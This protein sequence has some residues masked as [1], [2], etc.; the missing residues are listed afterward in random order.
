MKRALATDEAL[1]PDYEE[2]VERV[3]YNF[4]LKRRA[5]VQILGAGL[6]IA[7]SAPALAQRRGGRGGG[8]RNIA[9]RIHLGKDGT[10]TVMVGKVEAGQGAR[11]ELSQAAAEELRVPLSRIQLVMADTSLVPDDGITAGSGST[12]RTVPAVRQGAA[13]ARDLLLDFACKRWNVDRNAVQLND[14]KVTDT[15]GQ[16]TLAYADLAASDDAAKV[17]QQPVPSDVTL[18]PVKEWKVLGNPARRPNGRDI[19]TGAHKYPSDI[20]RPGM[21]YGKVLRAPS[22]GAKLTSVDLGPAKAMK[23]VV[24]VQDGQFVGVAAPTAFLAEQARAAIASTAKWESSPHPASKDLFEY[25]KQ[26]A[27]GSAPANPFAD[28]LAKAK[29]VLR[30]SYHVAYVQHAPLEPRAAVAEWTD[31]KLTVWAGTQNPFGYRSDL[32]RA[33]HLADDRVRVVVPDL[34]GGF[35]GKHTGEAAEEAA[36]LAQAAA[37]P[38]SL[39]WT[40]EEEFTWAYFRPAALIEAEA[41]LDAKGALTSWHF[42][43]INSGGSAVDTPYRSGKTR[44]QFLRSDA[45]LRQGSYRVLAATANNFARE[46]F[47]DELA[48]AAGADPLDFRLA[49]LENARLRA[50]L[51]TAAARFNWKQRAGT[52]TPNTGVGLACGTEKG[53]YV[54][55]C[56]EVGINAG[57]IIVR[58]VCQVFECGAILNPDNLLSQVQGAVIMGLGP[59]LREEMRFEQGAMLNA[60]FRKYQVPRFQDVPELDIHLLNRPD[61]ASAGAG[62][63]PI[64]VIAPA[65]ANAVFH[66]TGVPVR[67]MPISLPKT[68]S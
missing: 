52:K 53:S 37:K 36:R 43:N 17:F 16:R 31:G 4:G 15:A 55:A 60:S 38:V 57:K 46:S 5:F 25:L 32:M 29:H 19:V 9:A 28:E 58:R 13:A 33:F 44:C 39:R 35:G 34:G 18:T 8:T 54:A 51:E 1:P 56:V 49:H 21:L 50:V 12:P 63:T 27:Q 20:I 64:M 40:R 42:I 62:E 68:S 41:S 24:A 7:V 67:T 47:M 59:A 3:D 2:A 66:A 14:G 48:A 30:Q 11:T 23:D 22:F 6:L 10:I 61:L 26:H 45:P 65:I